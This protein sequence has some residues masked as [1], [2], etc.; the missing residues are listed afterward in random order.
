MK[1]CELHES[2]NG[3]ETICGICSISISLPL[4]L[5]GSVKTDKLSRNTWR[6]AKQI[7]KKTD[8]ILKNWKKIQILP[9][10]SNK[11]ENW[12]LLDNHKILV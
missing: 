2:D 6:F 10:I 9:P 8:E 12:S 4:H 5:I 3:K 11:F 1:W 7:C